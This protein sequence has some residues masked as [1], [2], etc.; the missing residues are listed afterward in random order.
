LPDSREIY[1]AGTP[2]LEA[3]RREERRK[4][5]GGRERERE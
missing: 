2:G 4:G 5:V 1:R 3:E